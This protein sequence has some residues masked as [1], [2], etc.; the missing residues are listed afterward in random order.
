[1]PPMLFAGLEVILDRRLGLEHRQV[2]FPRSRRKR[3]RKKWRRNRANWAAR[4]PEPI[5]IQVEPPRGP[6]PALELFTCRRPYLIAN[7]P[8]LELIEKAAKEAS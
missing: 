1:M 2:R 7:P 4:Y 8:G 6:I 3:I 5:V